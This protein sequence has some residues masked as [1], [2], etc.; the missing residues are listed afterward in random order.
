[1]ASLSVDD[2][3]GGRFKV[4]WRELVPGED[5]QPKRGADGRLARRSRSLTVEGK[6]ARD[7]LVARVRRA[8]LEE[9]EYQPP[10]A[11]EAPVVANLESAALAWTVYKA[12]R[13]TPSSV[14]LYRQH[15]KAFFDAVRALEGIAANRVV[16]ASI[17]SR[18]LL[19]RVVRRLQEAGRSES[20][21]YSVARSVLEMWRWAADD[22][23][24]YPGIPTPPREAKAVLP[25][26]P[27]Y[28]APPA[29]TMAE[30]DAAL[31]HLPADAIQSRR[32][33]TML[34][35]TGL[36]IFQVV[37]VRRRDLDL[38]NG[39]LT[40]T[41]GKSR[42][43]KAEM[44]TIPVCRSL[45]AE[46]Q[47]WVAELPANALLFPAWGVI[48]SER[49]AGIRPETFAAAW[50]EAVRWGE[51]REVAWKPANRK[52]GRP[53]HAFRAA[54]QAALRLAGTSE[55][56]IDEL[57]G[58]HGKTV[59]SRHYAA[60]DTLLAP[61]RAAVDSLPPIDWTGPRDAGTVIS[62]AKRRR[63]GGAG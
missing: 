36:R 37:N 2:L 28:A 10:T 26:P 45:I 62:L 27:I 48:G 16:S 63:A 42:A 41:T 60:G 22:P 52:T 56:V 20:H 5:G 32:I 19:T 8:L 50:R 9:G 55:T 18:D 4:R 34:R 47:P 1:M 59:R 12:T 46:I 54:F 61:M 39:L 49:K 11:S 40:V 33:G 24:N 31:R 57:V 43:E 35:Y 38:G 53:E 14:A 15:M 3:G 13:C 29:P 25:Q 17:L 51:A 44:R 6:D 7:E 30:C 23:G 58:H 21:V